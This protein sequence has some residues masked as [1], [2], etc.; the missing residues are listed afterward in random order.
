MSETANVQSGPDG[1]C[2]DCEEARPSIR[3][4]LSVGPIEMTVVVCE[5]CHE[6]LKAEL[7]VGS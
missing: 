7:G 1:T 5:D 6:E 3:A 4:E 2:W